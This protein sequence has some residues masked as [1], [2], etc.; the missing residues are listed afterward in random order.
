[1]TEPR[2]ASAPGFPPGAGAP[3]TAVA[4][5]SR[6]RADALGIVAV[7][8][9]GVVLVPALLVFLVGLIP[10]MNA[11]WWLGLFLIPL[12]AIAGVAALA[13]AIP[14]IIV[15]ARRGGGYALSITG[16]VLGALMLV[17]A[18]WVYVGSS[19]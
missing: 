8:V 9:A 5:R 15:G 7:I 12:L 6:R 11:I 4:A 19:L 17:P 3:P 1:M 10:S 2:D 18:F 14:G 13:L 16:T